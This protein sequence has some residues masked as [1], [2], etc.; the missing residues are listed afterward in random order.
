[1]R[2]DSFDER[3]LRWIDR[4]QVDGLTSFSKSLMDL[5]EAAWFWVA[6]AVAG[7]AVVVYLRAWRVGLA[8]GLASYFGGFVSAQL[9]DVFERPRPTFPDALVQV[10]GYAMPSSHACFTM[11]VSIALLLVIEWRSRRALVL[12]ATG[13]ALVQLLIGVAMV[14]LGA[15]WATDVIAGWA[16]GIPIGLLFGLVFRKRERSA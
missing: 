1:M 14:Y 10:G 5:S 8:V 4:N 7:V 3:L 12:S 2:S 15:H 9:K 13:L 6:V 16:L 11:A